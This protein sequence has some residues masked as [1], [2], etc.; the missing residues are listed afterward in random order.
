MSNRLQEIVHYMDISPKQAQV[1]D[2]SNLQ[3]RENSQLGH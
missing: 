1:E 2:Q 3:Y